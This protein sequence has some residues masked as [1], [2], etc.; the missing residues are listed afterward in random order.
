MEKMI[1]LGTVTEVMKGLV[2]RDTMMVCMQR[3]GLR[4]ATENKKILSKSE[5]RLDELISGISCISEICL[6]DDDLLD[7]LVLRYFNN[8]QFLSDVKEGR[9]DVSGLSDD[10]SL[11]KKT[12]LF[13]TPKNY[14]P[15]K[16]SSRKSPAHH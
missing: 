7:A 12:M 9:I 3:C 8:M 14:A 13:K 1:F 2:S 6:A 15:K 4:S 16:K 11:W 10:L 5:G